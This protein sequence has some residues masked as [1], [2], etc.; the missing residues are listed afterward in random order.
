MKLASVTQAD[1]YRASAR[2]LFRGVEVLVE[3]K[4]IPYMA[5]ALLAGFVVENALKAYLAGRV[6]N[7]TDI[8]APDIRH[9]LEALWRLAHQEALDVDGDPPKWCVDLNGLHR[10]GKYFSRYHTGAHGLTFPVTDAMLAG[11]RCLLR[12]TGA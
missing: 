6:P 11:I 5:N 9:D 12:E 3:Q 7:R 8:R 10:G 1:G 4:P 2:E